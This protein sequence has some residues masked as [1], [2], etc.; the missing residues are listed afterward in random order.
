VIAAVLLAV[1]ASTVPLR[2]PWRG[3]LAPGQ[4]WLTG[5]TL[6]FV[7]GW[8]QEGIWESRLQLVETPPTAE[9]AGERRETKWGLPGHFL[10]VYSILAPLGVYSRSVAFLSVAKLSGSLSLSI[11]R[12]E[13]APSENAAD[14]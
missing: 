4:H 5:M 9:Y 3:H 11:H 8:Y 14:E 7:K 2:V 12:S 13:E 6:Q 10:L 1:F